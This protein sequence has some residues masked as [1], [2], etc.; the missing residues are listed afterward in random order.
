MQ[1]SRLGG[2]RRGS[3]CRRRRCRAGAALPNNHM[4][5]PP[6][7]HTNALP[8]EQHSDECTAELPTSLTAG[9]QQRPP[10]AQG[11]RR[12]AAEQHAVGEALPAMAAVAAAVAAVPALLP[13]AASA[14]GV[15]ATLVGDSLQQHHASD[16]LVV[17][18]VCLG[19]GEDARARHSGCTGV[20]R[21]ADA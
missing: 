12:A 6:C 19:A 20:A 16:T 1:R 10:A 18:C 5:P 4:R 2:W 17:G 13:Q 11:P 15:L 8:R 3:A 9:D 7:R 14:S 21:N